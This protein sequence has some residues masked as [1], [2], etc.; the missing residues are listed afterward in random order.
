[1]ENRRYTFPSVGCTKYLEKYGNTKSEKCYYFLDWKMMKLVCDTVFEAFCNAVFFT[2]IN[3]TSIKNLHKKIVAKKFYRKRR[4][5]FASCVVLCFIGN[6]G[7]YR[8]R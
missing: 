6:C 4:M 1:M 5:P 2:V 3:E 7:L 8:S